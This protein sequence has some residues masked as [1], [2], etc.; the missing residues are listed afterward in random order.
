MR[1]TVLITNVMDHKEYD[2]ARWKND[3]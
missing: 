1:Q 3:I 2:K